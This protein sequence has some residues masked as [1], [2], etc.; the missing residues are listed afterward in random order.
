MPGA[1]LEPARPLGRG[2]LSPLRL[3]V[4]P[5]GPDV[6]R[7]FQLLSV[8]PDYMLG[9]YSLRSSDTGGTL[10]R[11]RCHSCPLGPGDVTLFVSPSPK[12]MY[13]GTPRKQGAYCSIACIG[14][15]LLDLQLKGHQSM[16][17]DEELMT[18]VIESKK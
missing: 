8:A 10:L 3:P 12:S 17:L 1:G 16:D 4:P 14:K 18:V 11:Y 2:I 9:W 15:K 13:S 7:V 6:L 5:P